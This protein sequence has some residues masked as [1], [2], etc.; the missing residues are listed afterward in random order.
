M[1]LWS[2]NL[3][4][5]FKGSRHQEGLCGK[6]CHGLHVDE[7]LPNLLLTVEE[8]GRLS[9]QGRIIGTVEPKQSIILKVYTKYVYIKSH[10]N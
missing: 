5:I 4:Q 7:P 6:L 9:F 10:V 1:C 8:D 3:L 2:T